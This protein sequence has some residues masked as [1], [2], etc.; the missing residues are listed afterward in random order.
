MKR[1]ITTF[2][3][4]LILANLS[5][6]CLA[7][8]LKIKTRKDCLQALQ[9]KDAE[10][11]RLQQEL[12]EKEAE[13]RRLRNLCLKHGINTTEREITTPKEHEVIK[14][15]NDP[16]F[17]IH[18]G[19]T[20]ASLAKTEKITTSSYHFEDSDYP[21]EIWDVANS[22][23]TIKTMRIY[24]FDG[25][26]YQLAVNFRDASEANYEAIKKQ[27]A[28]KYGEKLTGLDA[29]GESDFYP[30]I[31]G[32]EIVIRLNRDDNIFDDDILELIY[33]HRPLYQRVL[34]ELNRRK[35][36]KVRDKL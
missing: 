25:Y 31:D 16:L 30:V 11:E 4:F 8:E 15:L 28:E 14:V 10:I 17:G 24:S 1:I 19:Q 34:A 9:E 7:D 33:Y 20:L 5:S 21:A 12:V 6:I 23:P 2:I 29:F 36:A 13:I 35:A 18:L 27:L 3:A 26:V 32:V 22:D